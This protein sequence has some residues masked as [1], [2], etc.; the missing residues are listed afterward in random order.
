[1]NKFALRLLLFIAI[2]LPILYT[3]SFIIDTGLR[4]SHHFYY[5][6][7][8]D[9]MKGKINAD[10]LIMGSSRAWVHVSPKI[11]DTTLHINSYNLGMDGTQFNMQYDRFKLYRLHNKQPKYIIQT[12]DFTILT[13]SN[14]L[15]AYQQFL[16]Y[17]YD[18]SVRSLTSH[19]IGKFGVGDYYF[20]L[21]KYNNELPVAKEG[22]MS[23]FNKGVPALKYKGY[24]GQNKLWDSTFE[25]F[26]NSA[27]EGTKIKVD[28][29]SVLLMEEFLTY[30]QQNGIKVILVFPPVY[31]EFLKY[32]LNKDE[33]IGL[34]EGL[35]TK[36]DVPFLNYLDDD[37]SAHKENFYN[38]Q[39]MNKH[40]A[41]E[42]SM[43]LAA[44]ITP[45]IK[46][47]SL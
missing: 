3:A 14:L 23:F 35:H 34:Y 29:K 5:S 7:W 26:V 20:P 28:P 22:L 27:P 6:E 40:A 9:L 43:K 15:H 4:K 38:S 45:I 47:R 36:Y 31:S 8:N 17:L 18:T 39:H 19:Y 46:G 37:L 16:P 32:C 12:L 42:F 24:Q 41:E 2:P 13:P 1:M 11:L 21:Y 44:D 33:I 30:C 25:K 10:L